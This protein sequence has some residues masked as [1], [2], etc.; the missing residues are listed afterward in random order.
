MGIA[1]RANAFAGRDV[2]SKVEYVEIGGANRIMYED[3][4]LPTTLTTFKGPA[5]QKSFSNNRNSETMVPGP[6]AGNVWPVWSGFEY[7]RTILALRGE[8]YANRPPVVTDTE[9]IIQ[10]VAGE[11][12]EGTLPSRVTGRLRIAD[13][14]NPQDNL[15]FEAGGRA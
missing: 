14:M 5:V 4:P 7:T 8:K 10:L 11:R 1:S 3:A 15:F 2:V 6:D 9:V 12:V 13:Y